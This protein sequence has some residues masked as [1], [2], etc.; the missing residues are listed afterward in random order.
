MAIKKAKVVYKSGAK[1]SA[2]VYKSALDP[3]S[4][5]TPSFPSIGAGTSVYSP[6]NSIS[7]PV[8]GAYSDAGLSPSDVNAMAATSPATQNSANKTAAKEAVAPQVTAPV[9]KKAKVKAKYT[10]GSVSVKGQYA[11][12]NKT[13][14]GTYTE[15][16][17]QKAVKSISGRNPS[18]TTPA[19]KA[20]AKVLKLT[21]DHKK[22]Y[23]EFLAKQKK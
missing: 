11:P 8:T 5:V 9:K 4:I 17:V 15:P 13:P 10:P 6:A 22:L 18:S 21:G 12:V 7:S 14:S 2:P 1:K 3:S 19:P 16:A 23:E 20:T